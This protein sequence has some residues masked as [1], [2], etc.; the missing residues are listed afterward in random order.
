VWYDST[1]TETFYFDDSTWWNGMNSGVWEQTNDNAGVLYLLGLPFADFSLSGSVLTVTVISDSTRYSLLQT[2]SATP[3]HH[4]SDLTRKGIYMAFASDKNGDALGDIF[5]Y[6]VDSSAHLDSIY[7]YDTAITVRTVVIDSVRRTVAET[8]I[9]KRLIPPVRALTNRPGLDAMPSWSPDGSKLAYVSDTLG[10]QA[11]WV[12]SLDI[13]GNPMPVSASL[14]QNP[15]KL[16]NPTADMDDANP[17]WSPD[18]HSICFERKAGGDPGARNVF[19]IGAGD[20]GEVT[21]AW[22]FTHT[23]SWDCFNPEWSPRESLNVILFES[24]NSQ[25]SSDW[26]VYWMSAA[27]SSGFDSN[28]GNNL[29]NPNRNGHPTWSPD[30]RYFAYE[31]NP[32][33]Q[34][35]TYDIQIQPFA[36][37]SSASS[38]ILLT[39]QTDQPGLNRYPTWLPNGNLIAFMREHDIWLIDVSAGFELPTFRK[40]LED[41]SHHWDIAW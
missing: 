18:G 31:R 6:T 23:A 14:P 4:I 13:F 1:H 10:I 26:D 29:T 30:C 33:G 41:G 17:S 32:P 40:L 37:T 27:D 15:A 5:I 2:S 25:Q 38:R 8:T 3:I 36:D 39:N 9:V 34:D 22:N 12:L 7:Y 16:T 20:Y 28:T 35:S 24:K 21:P 11:V 19:I